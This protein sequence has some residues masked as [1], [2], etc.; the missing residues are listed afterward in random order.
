MIIYYNLQ[1]IAEKTLNKTWLIYILI[2]IIAQNYIIVYYLFIYLFIFFTCWSKSNNKQ[3]ETYNG[4]SKDRLQ[5]HAA[6]I[7]TCKNMKNNII[8]CIVAAEYNNCATLLNYS[9]NILLLLLN[10]C[11]M[12]HCKTTHISVK[13]IKTTHI[14]VKPILK[15]RIWLD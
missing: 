10:Q 1:D 6:L 3:L 13:S 2:R 5:G 15:R 9:Y 4:S 12:T 8:A 14:S 7:C 11:T